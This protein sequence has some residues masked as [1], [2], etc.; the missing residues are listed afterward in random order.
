LEVDRLAGGDEGVDLG[1]VQQDD[2]GRLGVEPGRGDQRIGDIAEQKLGLAVAEDRLSR[3]R[4]RRG[5][6]EDEREHQQP[7]DAGQR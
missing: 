6:G 3:S 5:E 4:P 7:R 1:I 2:V